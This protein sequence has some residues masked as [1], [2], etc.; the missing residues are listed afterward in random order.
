MGIESLAAKNSPLTGTV[1]ESLGE[2]VINVAEES[3]CED[4]GMVV[5]SLG[6]DVNIA[7]KEE[8][9]ATAEYRRNELETM[10]VGAVDSVGE[11]SRYLCYFYFSAP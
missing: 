1:I 4:A 6:D 3:P 8:K 5:D 2:D 10:E 9:N 7:A 11:K